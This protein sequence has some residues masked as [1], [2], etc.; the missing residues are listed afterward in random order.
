[1]KYTKIL[2]I[3]AFSFFYFIFTF[4]LSADTIIDSVYADPVLDGTIKFSQNTQSLEVNNWIPSMGA[5]DAGESLIA[6]DP[7]SYD[8]AYVSFQLLEIPEGYE[9]DS[10]Y[11][12][13]YQYNS[14]GDGDIWGN[15]EPYPLFYGEELPCIMDHIDYGNQLDVSDWT[16]GDPGDTGT[17]QTNIGTISDSGEDWS[18]RYM[19]ITEFVMDDYASGRDKTQYR[20]RF[21]VDT[22]WDYLTDALGF[23]TTNSAA[24]NER[25]LI[26]IYFKSGNSID[27]EV[28]YDAP[29]VSVYPNPFSYS[30]TITFS[31]PYGYLKNRRLEIYNVQGQ[32][33]R[34]LDIG[35]EN[36]IIWDGKDENDN[37]LSNG[38]YLIKIESKGVNV[39][40][41]VVK[42]K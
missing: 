14:I 22:D 28:V 34:E 11:V 33:I 16:K 23:S 9:L 4:T 41:K 17:I 27:N 8:R 18:Y 37:V 25:P 40:K 19:D 31:N 26:F 20:I 6:S 39:I 13:L 29:C 7:N 12:R 42:L 1:M 35:T 24:V 5:G 30:L 36:E 32:L 10:V 38:L 15:Q 3:L 21:E 2:L